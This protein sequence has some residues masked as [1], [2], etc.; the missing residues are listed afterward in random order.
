MSKT[1]T[2]GWETR[3]CLF[4]APT[5]RRILSEY[6]EAQGFVER[7]LT[8]VGGIVYRRFEVFLEVSYEPDTCPNYSPTIVLG[9]GPGKYDA[10]GRPGGVPFW[11]V[12]P[13]SLPERNYTFWTFKTEGDL[14]AVLARI[15]DALLEPHARPLWQ[16][17]DQLEKYIASFRAEF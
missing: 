7:E 2:E 4:F 16:D 13:D 11:F 10:G 14:E 9:I 3:N 5:C 6:L 8:P 12:I 15:K 1:A 17:V